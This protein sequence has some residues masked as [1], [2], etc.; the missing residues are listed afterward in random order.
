MGL[1][2]DF[3]VTLTIDGVDFGGWDQQTGGEYDSDEQK[4]TPFDGVQRT[5]LANKTTGNVTLSRDYRP[6]RDGPM[7]RAKDNL[8]GKPAIAVVQ[9]KDRNGNFQQNR[10]PYQGLIKAITPPETDS[11]GSDVA[12]ISV[13]ISVGIAA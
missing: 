10:P 11:D 2:K 3:Y 13:E 6:D 12:K 4:Y 1:N 5:Y 9:D 7:V 8:Q